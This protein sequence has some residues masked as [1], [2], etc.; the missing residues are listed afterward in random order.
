MNLTYEDS[1]VIASYYVADHPN[2]RGPVI[3]DLENLE[4][5]HMRSAASH[6]HLA[7][8]FASGKLFSG[9]RAAS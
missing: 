7:L 6:V 4:E 5:L 9:K 1:H 2:H 3:I 8:L